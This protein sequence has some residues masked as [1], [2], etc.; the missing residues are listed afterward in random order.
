MTVGT[1]LID[2]ENRLNP[3]KTGTDAGGHDESGH[4]HAM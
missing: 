3:T 4:H 1:F 2:A